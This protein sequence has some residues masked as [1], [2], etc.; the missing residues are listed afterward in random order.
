MSYCINYSIVCQN[1][2]SDQWKKPRNVLCDMFFKNH[3]TFVG[4]VSLLSILYNIY[5]V[6]RT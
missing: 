6:F 4:F 2:Y 5:Y 1:K 3:I